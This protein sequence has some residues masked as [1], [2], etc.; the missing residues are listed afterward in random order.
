MDKPKN[1]NTNIS[2]LMFDINISIDT[3]QTNM[4]PLYSELEIE[5][6]PAKEIAQHL[7]KLT[8]D[9]NRLIEQIESMVNFYETKHTKQLNTLYNSLSDNCLTYFNENA[10]ETVSYEQIC[11]WSKLL[12]INSKAL[13]TR[14]ATL[15]SKIN[16]FKYLSNTARD[17]VYISWDNAKALSLVKYLQTNKNQAQLSRKFDLGTILVESPAIINKSH[18]IESIQFLLN[19]T[20]CSDKLSKIIIQPCS[21]KKTNGTDNNQTE[22]AYTPYHKNNTIEKYFLILK[23]E[24]VELKLINRILDDTEKILK[25]L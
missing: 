13:I 11:S 19:E 15:L 6:M 18:I 25:L 24:Q 20:S 3:Y 4:P 21:R 22:L 12:D 1:T 23:S 2:K 9:S 5:N 14:L 16:S 7:Q 17:N 10:L 8:Y